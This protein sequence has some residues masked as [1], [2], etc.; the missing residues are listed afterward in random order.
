MKVAA[1][2]QQKTD[3]QGNM[4]LSKMLQKYTKKKHTA[5]PHGLVLN[6][7]SNRGASNWSNG[8][9][10]EGGNKRNTDSLY[11]LADVC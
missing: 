7:R 5:I 4:A 9:I 1:W 10:N 3:D 2:S 8:Q 11:S 6:S